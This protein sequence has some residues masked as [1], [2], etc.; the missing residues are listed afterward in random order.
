MKR[1]T[2]KKP[3]SSSEVG[4]QS[5]TISLRDLYGLLKRKIISLLSS[6]T[7]MS[8]LCALGCDAKLKVMQK[9]LAK[10]ATQAVV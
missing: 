5:A 1:T 7:R 4:R 2:K 3:T 8:E 10:E 6:E 9:H